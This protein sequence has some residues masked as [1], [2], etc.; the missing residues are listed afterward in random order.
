[1]REEV[2]VV[3]SNR[4][5]LTRDR[6][7]R[8]RWDVKETIAELARKV[9]AHSRRPK[10]THNFANLTLR[11][12]TQRKDALHTIGVKVSRAFDK[13]GEGG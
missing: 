12:P 9:A 4:R 7:L 2:G 1:M 3:D 10:Q 11:I 8:K 13:S 5:W 6:H